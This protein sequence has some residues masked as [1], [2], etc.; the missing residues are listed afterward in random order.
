MKNSGIAALVSGLTM[1]SA[2][3]RTARAVVAELER[4]ALARIETER[5]L[6]ADTL[7]RGGAVA[8]ESHILDVWGAWYRDA[9]RTAEDIEVGGSDDQTKAAI[10][11]SVKRVED[12]TARAVA[13]LKSPTNR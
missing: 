7:T 12:A 13:S 3:G 8:Y 6:S 5:K 11:A 1:A 4:A 10:A 9:V 2:D